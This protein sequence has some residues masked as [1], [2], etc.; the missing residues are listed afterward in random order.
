MKLLS[1]E[2]YNDFECIGANCPNSCCSGGWGID[3]D[4]VS[5][6]YYLSVS[7]DFGDKLRNNIIEIEN[8]YRFKMTSDGNCSFLNDNK[9]C[10]IYR[11]LGEDSLCYV[12]K[13][14]PRQDFSAGDIVFRYLTTSCPEVTRRIIQRKERMQVD[15]ADVTNSKTD[16]RETDWNKFNQAIR[17]YTAGMEILQNRN[18]VVRDRLA[19]LMLFVKQF[20]EIVHKDGDPAAIISL[21]STPDLYTVLLQDIPMNVRNFESKI[22]VFEAFYLVMKNMSGKQA[23][24]KRFNDLFLNISNISSVSIHDLDLSF[25]MFNSDD[26]QIELEQILTYRYFSSFMSGYEKQDYYEKLVQEC[27]TLTAFLCLIAFSKIIMDH[28][29]TQEERIL[30]FSL[31]SRVDHY[32]TVDD[33]IKNM[34]DDFIPLN[35]LFGLIS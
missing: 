7:G 17:V 3:V 26:I 8:G 34:I 6:D 9:L 10:E 32:K 29:C 14:Y 4:K 11:Q 33:R 30:L 23:V 27:M 24:R 16:Y 31:I 13:T 25:E 35:N 19:L 20:Q 2:D 22:K 21:F 18:L 15:C 28:T 1:V 5:G 12:C